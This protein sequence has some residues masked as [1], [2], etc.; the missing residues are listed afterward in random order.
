M[1]TACVR[2]NTKANTATSQWYNVP[3][4]WTTELEQEA[5]R[6]QK[7]PGVLKKTLVP[8]LPRRLVEACCEDKSTLSAVTQW[9][10]GC[11]VIK[12]TESDDFTS[13]KGR[14]KALLNLKTSAD[15]LWFSSPCTGGSSW[16]RVNRAKGQ[17]TAN[18]IDGYWKEFRKLWTAFE[19]VATHAIARQC[20]VFVE[21][22][23]GCAYWHDERVQKFLR[24]H[25][26]VYADF[27]GCMHELVAQHGANVGEPIYKPWRVACLNSSLRVFLHTKCDRSHTHA[28]CAGQDTKGTQGYTP[29]IARLVHTAIRVDAQTA[30]KH[31][32]AVGSMSPACPCVITPDSPM[33]NDECVARSGS[34]LHGD[35]DLFHPVHDGV[36]HAREG[37]RAP[38]A[39]WLVSCMCSDVP[40]PR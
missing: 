31:L 25:G 21:W 27:D 29:L 33:F 7:S 12:I 3:N 24:K 2:T 13:P 8:P 9:S 10:E 30:R 15:A 14:S 16:Q 23:R 40:S 35:W 1:P 32:E 17:Q 11:S 4:E 26:F 20:M 6:I 34:E 28:P 19:L 5:K 22:P 37:C 39:H 38:R 18:L 36:P